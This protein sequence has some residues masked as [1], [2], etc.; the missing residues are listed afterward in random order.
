MRDI[1]QCP[2]TSLH[3]THAHFCELALGSLRAA[4]TFPRSYIVVISKWVDSPRE[5]LEG[6]TDAIG[7]VPLT[8]SLVVQPKP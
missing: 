2:L 4:I 6:R 7:S 1:Y 3:D 5:E 8:Q